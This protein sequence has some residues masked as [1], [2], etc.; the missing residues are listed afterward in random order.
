MNSSK[1]GN[2]IH[3]GNTIVC[4]NKSDNIGSIRDAIEVLEAA[5]AH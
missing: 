4:S 3:I 1:L 5:G 2:G